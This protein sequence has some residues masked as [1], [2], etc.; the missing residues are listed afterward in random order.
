MAAIVTLAVSGLLFT[1]AG[2]L[3]FM[4][5]SIQPVLTGSMEPTYG[6]G[7][8]IVSRSIPTSSIRPGM[9]VI[10]VPPGHSASFAHRVVAVGG[11]PDRPVLTT[12]GDANPSPDPWHALIK[13][14][15][16]QEVIWQVPDL[17][18]LMVFLQGQ[19]MTALLIILAGLF[20]VISGTKSILRRPPPPTPIPAPCGA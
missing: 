18:R 3:F 20:V 15:S 6:P 5:L 9:I 17:G 13:A 4:H 19:G 1:A 11:K 10:F 2:L 8:A 14:H 7:W 12:K 16:V